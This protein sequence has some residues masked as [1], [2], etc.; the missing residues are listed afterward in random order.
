MVALFREMGK[1]EFPAVLLTEALD[2]LKVIEIDLPGALDRRPEMRLAHQAI[3]Q[4]QANW[5]LQRANAKPD[6]DTQLGYK[7][8]LGFDTLYAAVQIP[9][10]VRNRNQG[11]IAAAEGELKA[12]E[13]NLKAAEAQIRA[14]V[15]IAATDYE[16]RRRLVTETLRP[17][18][19]EA[20]EVSRIAQAAYREGGFDLLRLIDSERARL[21]AEILYA[22]TLAEYQQSAV[23][24]QI[25]LGTLR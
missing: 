17:M 10:P 25:A 5:R 16:A 2:G 24:L 7:R 12:A 8:T 6:I 20:G 1:S 22:R 21:E 15:Q 19:E 13:A 4:A 9:L 14:D 3:E 23:A 18:R 11:Q